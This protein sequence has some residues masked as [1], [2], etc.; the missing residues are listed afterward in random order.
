MY[1]TRDADD[2]Q[3]NHQKVWG[4]PDQ[5]LP[6]TLQTELSCQHPDLR[7]PSSRT[8]TTDVCGLSPQPV[9][10]CYSSA[11]KPTWRLCFRIVLPWYVGQGPWELAP[12]AT[13]LSTV[14]VNDKLSTSKGGSLYFTS[15][16]SQAWALALPGMFIRLKLLS[17]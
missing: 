12:L 9:V 11:R 14:Y 8:E 1:K 6:H 16:I 13:L 3:E 2:F 7:L 4:R 17:L 5:I 10:S 15:R